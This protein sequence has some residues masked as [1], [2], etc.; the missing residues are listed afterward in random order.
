M[1]PGQLE[2]GRSRRLFAKVGSAASAFYVVPTSKGQ[3]CYVIVGFSSA[4]CLAPAPLASSGIDW[5]L[6][7]SDG[8]GT[9]GPLVVHGLVAD[10]IVGVD[11]V[12]GGEIQAA[13]LSNNGFYAELQGKRFPEALI[14]RRDGGRD[15]RIPVPQLPE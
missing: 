13:A 2:L 10:D 11:V 15:T 9:G 6:S 3:L 8:L 7:D 14:V 4:G 12:A 1:N 5:G